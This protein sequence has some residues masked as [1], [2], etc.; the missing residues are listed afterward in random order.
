MKQHRYFLR[1]IV[2]GLVLG[3]LLVISG[4]GP[5][6]TYPAATVPDSIEKICK[7]E[8]KLDVKARIVGKT[9]G[10]LLVVDDLMDQKRQIDKDVHEKMGKVSQVVRRVLLSSDLEADFC[11]VLVRDRKHGSE[12]FIAQYMDDVRRANAEAIGI[13][14]SLNRVVFGQP[15]YEE[16]QEAVDPEGAFILKDIQLADFLADQIGQRIRYHFSK[17]TK[18]EAE[19]AMVVVDGSYETK[20]AR[21]VFRFSVLSFKSG[22]ARKNILEMFK[23]ANKVLSAYKFK[24]F[25]L[26]EIRDYLNR[27]KLLVKRAT[28]QAYQEKKIKDEALLDQCLAQSRSVED[29]LKLFGISAPKNTEAA[30]QAALPEN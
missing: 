19:G 7:K 22:N 30:E 9:V 13:E 5:K 1:S 17:D 20:G 6:Y 2:H 10:A 14:E 28:L 4:C 8:Y 26:I 12:I 16:G 25:D 24:D 11:E 23:T 18:K 15:R 21:K 3:M 29:A 27:Q